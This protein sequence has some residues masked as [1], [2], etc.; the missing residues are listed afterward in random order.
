MLIDGRPVTQ[1]KRELCYDHASLRS[2]PTKQCTH[3][4]NRMGQI[5][6]QD[7]LVKQYGQ[8]VFTKRTN[9]CTSMV[10]IS[11]YDMGIK[12]TDKIMLWSSSTQK[13]FVQEIN[14]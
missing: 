1:K 10:T 4:D 5:S 8:N 11:K 3:C 14:N 6:V 13:Q 7:K 2:L 9:M 12:Q